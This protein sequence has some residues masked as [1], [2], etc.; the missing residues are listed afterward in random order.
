MSSYLDEF[1]DGKLS[2]DDMLEILKKTVL[3]S[4]NQIEKKRLE[5]IK[6][7]FRSPQINEEQST[8]TNEEEE[9]HELVTTQEHL[10]PVGTWPPQMTS[11]L[12]QDN[13]TDINHR[14]DL[15][16]TGKWSEFT[17]Q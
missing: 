8:T 9:E 16:L 17:N 11:Q 14:W 10:D 7:M 6:E 4:I 12:A 1:K 13:G 15:L 3:E 5:T 2:K